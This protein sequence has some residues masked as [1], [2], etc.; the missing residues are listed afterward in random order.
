MV[1]FVETSVSFVSKYLPLLEKGEF[2]TLC[3]GFLVTQT[4]HPPYSLT[5]E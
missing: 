4:N 3:L 5:T 2:R 1:D